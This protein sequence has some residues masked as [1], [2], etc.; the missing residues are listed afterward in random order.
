MDGE[1]G[2]EWGDPR[3]SAVNSQAHTPSVRVPNIGWEST[4][5][6][7]P[8]EDNFGWGKTYDRRWDAPTPRAARDGNPDDGDLAFGIDAREWEEEQVRLDRDW[9]N[10]AEDGVAGDED[11][12]PF[13]QYEESDT[14]KSAAPP[15]KPVV[16]L[17]LPPLLATH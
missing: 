2:S 9:Y 4:P 1:Q 3:P 11:S 8:H 17:H 5:R 10:T 15:T 12:N 14:V 7:D 16:R 13:S 6:V